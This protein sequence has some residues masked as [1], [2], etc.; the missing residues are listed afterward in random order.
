M[1]VEKRVG[2]EDVL[3]VFIVQPRARN[4]TFPVVEAGLS[5]VDCAHVC[6]SSREQFGL[7]SHAVVLTC[8]AV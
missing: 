7:L 2:V 5:D 4:M 8:I 3:Y 1:S 6:W